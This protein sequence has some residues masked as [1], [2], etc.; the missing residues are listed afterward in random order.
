[1]DLAQSDLL[2]WF[3]E[4]RGFGFSSH[5]LR[6]LSFWVLVFGLVF[7]GFV[8]FGVTSCLLAYV[9]PFIDV[10]VIQIFMFSGALCYCGFVGFGVC[11]SC[12]GLWVGF[13]VLSLLFWVVP[14]SGWV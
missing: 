11:V 12:V 4:P 9:F 10:A 3:D 7:V 6:F 1:M 5:C 2:F 8:G 13:G 14:Y